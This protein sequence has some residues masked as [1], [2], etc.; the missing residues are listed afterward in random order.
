MSSELIALEE[1]LTNLGWKNHCVHAGLVIRS[2]EEY[3]GRDLADRQ[4]ILKRMMSFV[5]HLDIKYK[6]IYIEKKHID[7]S[8][9]AT[10]KLSK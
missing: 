7:D 6:T 10:G 4:K 1:S 2:E 9:E 5:R 3:K 8:V